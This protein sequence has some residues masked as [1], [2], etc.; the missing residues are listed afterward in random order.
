MF[1]YFLFIHQCNNSKTLESLVQ[2]TELGRS[3]IRDRVKRIQ[4]RL[5]GVQV[6]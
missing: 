1:S 5:S 2:T 4:I 6:A 3:P